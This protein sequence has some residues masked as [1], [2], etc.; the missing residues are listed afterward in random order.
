MPSTK[1]Y[2]YDALLGLILL[3][4]ILAVLSLI[5]YIFKRLKKR[6]LGL[7]LKTIRIFGLEIINVGKQELIID[8]F[9]SLSQLIVSISFIYAALIVIQG[10]I[11]AT[12]E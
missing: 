8:T 6:L 11:P 10:L 3:L 2:A 7:N 9:I 4:L 12:E 5:D 1:E